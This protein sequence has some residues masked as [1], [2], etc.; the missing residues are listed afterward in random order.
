MRTIL[1]I[2]CLVALVVQSTFAD[3]VAF[4]SFGPNDAY[5]M[6]SGV[7]VGEGCAGFKNYNT[8]FQFTSLVTGEFTSLDA[9][10]T[11][12]NDFGTD[13]LEFLLWASDGNEIGSL[14]WSDAMDVGDV[15]FG[16]E[17]ITF[18][19]AGNGPILEAGVDYWLSAR[20]ESGLN[21]YGWNSVTDAFDFGN[22]AFD[23]QGGED[24]EY[25]IGTRSAF[26]INVQSIPEPSS[27]FVLFL[28]FVGFLRR[29]VA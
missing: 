25:V 14:I 9:A 21:S 26:R 29:K 8:A 23:D 20:A 3:E 10:F 17:I 4:S 5:N 18:A 7:A 12:N 22:G 15:Q 11:S 24:W 19:A 28:F 6:S 16:G 1:L 13:R 27:A 2:C